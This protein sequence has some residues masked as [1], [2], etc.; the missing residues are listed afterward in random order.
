[1]HVPTHILAGWV[2]ANCFPLTA[3]ERLAC[4]IVSAIPDLD[5]I[6]IVFGDDAYQRWYHVAG[7]NLPFAI[8]SSTIL[9]A[10]TTRGRRIVPVGLLYIALFHLHL[11]MDYWG[12]GPGWPIV[13]L[14]PFS[15]FRIVNW[16]AWNLSSWQNTLIAG[17]LLLITIVIGFVKRRTPLEKL[18]PSL[19]AQLVG[20]PRP[21]DPSNATM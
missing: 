12:S 17:V 2:A 10:C 21:I 15:N 6:G 19:D 5:G 14:W 7:H 11:F 16:Q 13:Y 8:I 4:M 20:K 9:V 3:G 1:M 18:M